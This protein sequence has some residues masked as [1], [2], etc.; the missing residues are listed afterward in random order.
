MKFSDLVR[1]NKSISSLRPHPISISGEKYNRSYSSFFSPII[2]HFENEILGS[3]RL[4]AGEKLGE[5]I[6]IIDEFNWSIALNEGNSIKVNNAEVTTYYTKCTHRGSIYPSSATNSPASADK[7]TVKNIGRDKTHEHILYE[8]LVVLSK[9]HVENYKVLLGKYNEFLKIKKEALCFHDGALNRILV[10][11]PEVIKE[12]LEIPSL[13]LFVEDFFKEASSPEFKRLNLPNSITAFESILSKKPDPLSEISDLNLKRE[14][15][16]KKTAFNRCIK[17][18][19]ELLTIWEYGREYPILKVKPYPI[20]K[21]DFHVSII[22]SEHVHPTDLPVDVFIGN[23]VKPLELDEYIQKYKVKIR[24]ERIKNEK[25]ARSKISIKEWH[26]I[27]YVHKTEEEYA[28]EVYLHYLN[29]IDEQWGK[30]L[31]KHIS[32]KGGDRNCVGVFDATYTTD[33]ELKKINRKYFGEKEKIHSALNEI[34]RRSVV[35][36]PIAEEL[37][38]QALRSLTRDD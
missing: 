1:R 9:G 14:Y 17:L 28:A 11:K 35:T 8:Q 5:P 31:H 29:R 34:Y 13:R 4:V 25:K 6:D 24:K 2:S 27:K 22:A 16:R 15:K 23:Q 30:S 32:V 36:V 38:I 7:S 10:L 20:E 3:E 21:V 26:E 18:F 33:E 37:A 12:L 19:L